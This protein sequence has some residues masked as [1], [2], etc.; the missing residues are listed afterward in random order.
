MKVAVLEGR[1]LAVRRLGRK[2]GSHLKA[3]ELLCLGERTSHLP[4]DATCL[5]PT[6][7]SGST[8]GECLQVRP[9]IG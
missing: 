5:L 6:R 4:E 3:D 1:V 8:E 7:L 9:T 2:A